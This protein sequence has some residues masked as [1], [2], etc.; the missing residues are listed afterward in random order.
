MSHR[1]SAWAI[2]LL[3][4]L[5]GPGL[6]GC[7]PDSGLRLLNFGRTA[8][9]TGDFDT[10]EQL[11]QEVA[12]T[13]QVEAEIQLY[14]G[15]IDGAHFQTE[16]TSAETPPGLQ[17][18]DLLRAETHA[19]LNQFKTAFFSC[20]MRG[21]AERVYN[22][23]SED[24]HLVNDATVVEHVHD[25]VNNGLRLYFSDW[26]YDLLEAAWPSTLD[27]LGDDSLLDDAQR[28]IEGSVN[29]RVVDEDLAAFMEVETGSQ[30]EIVFNQGGWAVIEDVGED[31]DV[32][33]EAEVQYDHPGTGQATTITSPLVVAFN[34]GG[35]RVVYTS[36][37]NEAQ[38]TDDAVDVLRYQLSQLSQ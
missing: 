8:I 38:I 34:S 2:L 4:L 5:V 24:H 22:G 20:G 25:A 32:L 27:W 36:F 12:N 11:I 28:G 17:V 6:S 33:V 30:I 18:E 37:H 19:G 10:V 21:V 13:T 16:V 26:S 15:Y 3:L 31:V 7:D 1:L 9:V 29:A 23:A 14:D 35:G